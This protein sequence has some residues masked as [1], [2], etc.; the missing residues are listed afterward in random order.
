MFLGTT[1]CSSLE[2]FQPP[3]HDVVINIENTSATAE[4]S[5][6]IENTSATAE[7]SLS[8]ENTSATAETSLTNS[9]KLEKLTEL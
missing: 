3:Q 6:S 4:T 9:L 1:R 5:L 7:T 8:I 2:E